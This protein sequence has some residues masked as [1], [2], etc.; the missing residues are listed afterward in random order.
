[1]VERA[2]SMR[3]V[4]GSKQCARAR[5]EDRREARDSSNGLDGIGSYKKRRY[6]YSKSS[7]VVLALMYYLFHVEVG[8]LCHTHICY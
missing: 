4:G 5:S 8:A 2:L 6:G 3:E 7:Q 1:M